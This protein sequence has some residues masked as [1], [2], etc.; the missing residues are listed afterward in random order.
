MC[1]VFP[2]NV[3]V[4]LDEN[5]S[6]DGFS[7]GVIFGIKLI[8]PMKCVTVLRKTNGKKILANEIQSL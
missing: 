8:K 4:S 7:N 1:K 5:L 6:Q 3:V 2:F